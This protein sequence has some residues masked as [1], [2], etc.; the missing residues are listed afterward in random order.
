MYTF[1]R[2]GREFLGQKKNFVSPMQSLQ[3]SREEYSEQESPSQFGGEAEQPE[4]QMGTRQTSTS[5]L[6]LKS[7]GSET[8]IQGDDEDGLYHLKG[9]EDLAD[10]LAQLRD[11]E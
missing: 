11:D 4:E 7:A 5:L 2:F 9:D 8:E 1:E 10:V 6:P 3:P